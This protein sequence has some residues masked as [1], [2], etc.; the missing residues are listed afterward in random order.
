[1]LAL[2]LEQKYFC[3]EVRQSTDVKKSKQISEIRLFTVIFSSEHLKRIFQTRM[4]DEHAP[5]RFER[6]ENGVNEA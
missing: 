4:Y 6:M 5:F 3:M 1:M 2:L